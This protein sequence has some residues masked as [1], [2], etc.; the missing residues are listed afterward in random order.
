MNLSM[1]RT[2][3]LYYGLD[4]DAEVGDTVYH[5][6][7]GY[8]RVCRYR[9]SGEY[10]LECHDG[11]WT[12]AS[13]IPSEHFASFNLTEYRLVDSTTHKELRSLNDYEELVPTYLVEHTTDGVTRSGYWKYENVVAVTELE[14]N[15]SEQDV[16][17][18]IK[19]WLDEWK[20][21]AQKSRK[22]VH[23]FLAKYT[24]SGDVTWAERTPSS[25]KPKMRLENSLDPWAEV[26]SKVYHFLY[27]WGEVTDYNSESN[28]PWAVEFDDHYCRYTK[29]KLGNLTLPVISLRKYEVEN[30]NPI[31][32]DGEYEFGTIFYAPEND[33]EGIYRYAGRTEDDDIVVVNSEGL[34]ITVDEDDEP[35]IYSTTPY[36]IK[37]VESPKRQYD[38]MA[39]EVKPGTGRHIG[40]FGIFYDED[41]KE[42]ILGTLKKITFNGTDAVYHD[43]KTGQVFKNFDPIK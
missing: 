28:C 12:Y 9:G 7:Y 36:T 26:G 33:D 18:I 22:N 3:D 2:H 11:R 42:G 21:L 32:R 20:E 39:D 43:L 35:E 25:D 40:D 8:M 14:P 10:Y 37:I 6:R 23:N 27:G 19:D 31:D 30:Y 24:D 29:L 16:D 13:K 17:Q 1:R 38:H 41:K 4:H 15:K 34:V 5:F